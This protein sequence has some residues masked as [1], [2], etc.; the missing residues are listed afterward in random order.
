[1]TP[2]RILLMMSAL[3]AFGAVYALYARAF[4]WLDGLPTLKDEMLVRA[5]GEFLP[6]ARPSSPTIDRLKQAF[7]EN[8]PETEP[9]FYPFQ[10]QFRNGETSL[11]LASGSPPSTPNSK[12]VTLSPFSVAIFSKPRPPHL[13][14]PG[15]VNEITTFHADKAVLEF[16]RKIET[17]ADMNTAKLIRL[18]LISDPEQAIPDTLKRRGHVHITNNQRSADSNRFLI[19]KTVGPMFY[20]DPKYAEGPDKLGPDVWTDAPIEIVD[21]SNLPRKAG[22]DAAVAPTASEET[23]QQ[24]RRRGHPGRSSTAAADRHRGRVAD[25]S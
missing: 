3:F 6:P 20:R 22:V 17:P 1:M 4:G 18:E 15:E 14:E 19:L 13:L 21:R 9:A 12:R 16:D 11:V 23:P 8:A 5:A 24:C 25:P 7:G 10:L 2:R